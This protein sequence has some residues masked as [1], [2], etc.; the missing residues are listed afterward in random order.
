MVFINN[1]N[2]KLLIDRITLYRYSLVK[3]RFNE[4]ILSRKRYLSAL[5]I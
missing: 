5:T 4:I 1:E 3:A 2:I